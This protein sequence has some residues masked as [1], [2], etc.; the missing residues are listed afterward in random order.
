MNTFLKN[1]TR[2]K[3]QLIHFIFLFVICAGKHNIKAQ[4][5]EE[6]EYRGYGSGIAIAAYH[7]EATEVVIPKSIDGKITYAIH[8]GAFA[9]NTNITSVSIPETVINIGQNA[10]LGCTNLQGTLRIPNSVTYIGQ[11][12]FR[13]CKGLEKL[14]LPS[15]IKMISEGAFR[16]CSKLAGTV[17][18]HGEIESIQPYSFAG[19]SSLTHIVVAAEVRS[20]QSEA[21]RDC[22][23][24][25]QFTI[26][27]S[28]RDI[29]KD[30]FL[31]CERFVEFVIAGE[32]QRLVAHEGVL[33]SSGMGRLIK[34]PT[35]K[36]G[37]IVVPSQ[38]IILGVGSFYGCENLRSISLPERLESISLES[39]AFCSNLNSVNLPE[40]ITII[41][42]RAFYQCESLTEVLIPK[43][44]KTIGAVAF[45]H[46]R[47][48][49]T[50]TIPAIVSEIDD[51]AFEGCFSL[52]SI[53]VNSAN[54]KYSSNDGILYDKHK[55]IL[56]KCPLAKNGTVTLLTSVRNIANDAF[57]DCRN[58]L[59]IKF[60]SYIS[61]IG[62]RAFYGCS[63]LTDL[64]LPN[65][66]EIEKFAF[67]DCSSLK[68]VNILS[69]LGLGSGSFSDCSS[70]ESIILP[71]NLQKIGDSAFVNCSNLT[72]IIV[73]S[74]NSH[75]RSQDGI[76]YSSDMKT[77]LAYPAGKTG[78]LS[79]PQTVEVILKDAFRNCTGLE[80]I[81]LPP[82]LRIISQGAFSGCSELSGVLTLPEGITYIDNATFAGCEKLEKIAFPS[83]ITQ[84]GFGAFAACRK[85]KSLVFPPSINSIAH[86]A[87]WGCENLR[88][89]FFLGDAPGIAKKSFRYRG[90]FDECAE[91]FFIYHFESSAGYTFPLFS[92]YP[93]IPLSDK[94]GSRYTE[95]KAYT[96]VP[97]FHFSRRNSGEAF[98]TSS[99]SQAH[100]LAKGMSW[101][102]EG[103]S[104]GL[105]TVDNG[106]SPVFRLLNKRTSRHYYTISESNKDQLVG[107]EGESY[108][109]EGVAFYAFAEQYFGSEPVHSFKQISNSSQF[110]SIDPTEIEQ[111]QTNPD[112]SYDG[113]SWYAWMW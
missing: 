75:F 37:S 32:N 74:A 46:C 68:T 35:G 62:S 25:I 86:S 87:F 76:L 29:E 42:D 53:L 41:P 101:I 39:F 7:G 80:K 70:L 77:L 81:E 44:V 28:V 11:D 3:F 66:N 52:K 22:K 38:T 106:G 1:L 79:V 105:P 63:G 83:T 55:R 50:I 2:T 14:E 72:K 104:H 91:D 90:A 24:L 13:D 99:I 95:N 20:I 40:G 103:I 96:G 51:S 6:F 21:F 30:A 56:I 100:D 111:L 98:Y 23:N 27:S 109:Y 71:S 94:M 48:I 85:L 5:F 45:A 12:A 49:Q 112:F 67:A 64:F 17:T 60:H 93:V 110:F 84:I 92:G 10:F 43:N 33:Y 113:I 26:P 18:I 82:S 31:G 73:S 16:D 65:V 47:S 69:L 107:S 102:L 19:C 9:Y 36:N 8:S 97:L 15:A 61:N 4:I 78:E 58:V 88:A 59:E 54:T 57:K 34:C 89:A 108:V